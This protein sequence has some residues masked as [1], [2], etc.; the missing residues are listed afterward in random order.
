MTTEIDPAPASDSERTPTR[1]T[2][3]T[4]PRIV[5]SLRAT[6]AAP[7]VGMDW[8]MDYP[9]GGFLVFCTAAHHQ[10]REQDPAL[11]QKVHRYRHHRLR[12]GI[13]RGPLNAFAPT[14]V[15]RPG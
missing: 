2:P 11:V 13:G 15:N 14:L 6:A 9:S 12:D 3:S 8:L 5:S 4:R 10:A 7:G 1:P